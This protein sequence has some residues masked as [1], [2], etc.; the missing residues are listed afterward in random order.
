[1][2][3]AGKIFFEQAYRLGGK[4][5]EVGLGWPIKGAGN[6]VKYFFKIIK[7][8]ISTGK[9]LDLGCGEGRISI[10]FAQ[11]GFVVHGIDFA[12]G[13]IKRAKKFA[14]EAKVADK[15]YFKVGN[16]LSLP[17]PDK[18]FDVVVDWSVFDHIEPK[19][20]NLYLKNLLRVLK[21]EGFYILTVF[22]VNTPWVACYKNRYYSGDAYFH[23]FTEKNIKEIFGKYFKIIKIYERLHSTPKPIFM[24]Y[25]ILMVKQ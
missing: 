6:E 16:V 1:M 12:Q 9:V 14:E 19:N 25:H 23:F 7:K 22:S 2:K 21:R 8:N 18:I 15:I 4:R 5:I 13:A 20:W 11:K 3:E 17:Y 24:F 10:F